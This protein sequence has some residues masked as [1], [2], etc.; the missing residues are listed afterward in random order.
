MRTDF[1]R[2]TEQCKMGLKQDGISTTS[3]YIQHAT[4]ACSASS[5]TSIRCGLV[6]QHTVQPA[7][8]QLETPYSSSETSWTTQKIES[9]R[10]TYDISICSE[11]VQLVV[12]LVLQQ[13][14]K[15]S[16]SR[17]SLDSRRVDSEQ[18]KLK[19]TEQR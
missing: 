14:H 15:P 11:V 9:L 6:E 1:R 19:R 13:I 16:R 18:N 8:Q 2:L 17:R 10:H 5:T 3:H 12:R 7:V 4:V